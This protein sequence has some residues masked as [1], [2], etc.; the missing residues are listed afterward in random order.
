MSAALARLTDGRILFG[1]AQLA[2]LLLFLSTT[3]GGKYRGGWFV[4]VVLLL[5]LL[6][7]GLALGRDIVAALRREN[8]PA[9]PVVVSVAAFAGLLVLVSYWVGFVAGFTLF[10][11]A[12]WRFVCGFGTGRA[13]ILAL[14]FGALLPF[15]FG[16]TLGLTLWRGAM[17]EVVPGFIGGSIPPPL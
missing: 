7:Q 9:R 5:T 10:L 14:A 4:I 17:V 13:A 16:W 8:P 6:F 2:L 15:A 11:F 3:L 12:T 1:A